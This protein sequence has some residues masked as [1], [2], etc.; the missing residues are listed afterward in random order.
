M[1]LA[2]FLVV[3]VLFVPLSLTPSFS[4]NNLMSENMTLKNKVA[5]VTIPDD[6]QL[7]WGFVKGDVENPVKWYPVIIQFF[8]EGKAVHFAQV[9]LSGGGS[10]EYKFQ[11]RQDDSVRDIFDGTYTVKV[12]AVVYSN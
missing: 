5:K 7:K 4:E 6:P 3:V 11:I 10:Y 8:K 2:L 9:N 1:K 12:Y